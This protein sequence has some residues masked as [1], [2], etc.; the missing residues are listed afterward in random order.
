[1]DSEAYEKEVSKSPDKLNLADISGYITVVYEANWWLRYVLQKNEEL[2]EVNI[3]FLH[4]AG[5]STSFS[6]PKNAD[7]LRI[8][9][10]DVLTKVNPVT[11]TGR[12]YILPE[13]EV[14]QANEAFS[15]L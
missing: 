10:M 1:M 2:D 13:S 15:K 7:I 9:V 14:C 5:P 4:P 6:Y 8:S 12:L 3:S 11:P